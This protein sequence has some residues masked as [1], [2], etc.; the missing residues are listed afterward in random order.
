MEKLQLENSGDMLKPIEVNINR[1][2]GNRFRRDSRFT[3]AIGTIGLPQ[4]YRFRNLL[5]LIVGGVLQAKGFVRAVMAR[6]S[7]LATRI[8][9]TQARLKTTFTMIPLT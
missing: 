3:P 2:V 7:R 6:I 5:Y 4:G 1:Q 8:M 9:L